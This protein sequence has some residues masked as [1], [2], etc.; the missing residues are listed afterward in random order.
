[1]TK[2]RINALTKKI[3]KLS[4]ENTAGTLLT[5]DGIK[6]V[7]GD[8]D[9]KSTL[10]FVNARIA[11]NQSDAGYLVK[12]A[13]FIDVLKTEKPKK[14]EKVESENTEVMPGEHEVDPETVKT[15]EPEPTPEPEKEQEPKIHRRQFHQF[16]D[17]EFTQTELIVLSKKLSKN[18]IEIF[19]IEDRKSSAVSQF[20]SEVA[21]LVAEN[22]E[23]TH[24]INSGSEERNVKCEASFYY[25]KDMKIITRIDT[26]EII[27]QGKIP[28][29]QRQVEGFDKDET[30]ENDALEEQIPDTEP[31]TPKTDK[32]DS[33]GNE[34]D[35][36]QDDKYQGPIE[37]PP[38]DIPTADPEKAHILT[39]DEQQAELDR[40][41]A[42]VI[43]KG[44]LPHL[45]N[46]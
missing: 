43:N 2:K 44:D 13:D 28:D 9:N 34:A 30:A 46:E 26:G 25:D 33:E 35:K 3:I 17:H 10:L 32:P 12:A 15:P 8:C 16:I 19:A 38:E 42:E 6:T 23:L 24:K 14:E 27:W 29:H 31:D 1:M 40:E 11:E 22:G 7:L 5:E 41:D 36:Y 37:K 45:P 20:K 18:I 4:Q 21:A 39:M